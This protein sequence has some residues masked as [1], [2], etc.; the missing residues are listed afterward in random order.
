MDCGGIPL[1][2]E[3]IGEIH[4]KV[5]Q[6]KYRLYCLL[7]YSDLDK[8][9]ISFLK[10]AHSAIAEM[11]GENVLVFSFE[12]FKNEVSILIPSIE[13]GKG[14]LN[15]NEA[16]RMAQ[17]LSI[18]NSQLPCMVFFRELESKEVAIYSFDNTWGYDHTSEHMKLVFDAVTKALRTTENNDEAHLLKTLDSEFKKIRWKKWAKRITTTHSLETLLRAVA[19]GSKFA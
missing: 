6:N 11:S 4:E 3:N 5:K 18:Q 15:R 19:T 14:F 17:T 9:F 7:L 10:C 13:S 12:F 2:V 16:I 8:P 1:L